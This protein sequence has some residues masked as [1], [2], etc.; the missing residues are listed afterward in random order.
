MTKVICD[1]CGYEIKERFK[2][3]RGD[4]D[5]NNLAVIEIKPILL[6]KTTIQIHN[7]DLCRNCIIKILEGKL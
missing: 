1:Y 2:D 3:Y 4:L 7:P 6:N 5:G